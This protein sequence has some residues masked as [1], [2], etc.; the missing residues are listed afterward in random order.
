METP[1]SISSELDEGKT[2][3]SIDGVNYQIYQSEVAPGENHP[4][5]LLKDESGSVV[6]RYTIN[7][8]VIERPSDNGIVQ[9]SFEL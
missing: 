4:I 5:F 7:G 2:E 3:V 9:H 6:G 1:S 8:K